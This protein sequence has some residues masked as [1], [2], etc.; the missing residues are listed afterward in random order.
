MNAGLFDDKFIRFT[1]RPVQFSIGR[2][3]FANV[4]HEIYHVSAPVMVGAVPLQLGRTNH[5]KQGTYGT[6]YG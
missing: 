6:K 3:T 5:T 2:R 1:V 4:G